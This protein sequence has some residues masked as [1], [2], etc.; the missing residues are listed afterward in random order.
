MDH[1]LKFCGEDARRLRRANQPA[2]LLASVKKRLPRPDPEVQLGWKV[3]LGLAEPKLP[4]WNQ[5]RK[6]QI[7]ELVGLLPVICLTHVF[8]GLALVSILWG[9]APDWQ[10]LIWFGATLALMMSAMRLGRRSRKE[11]PGVAPGAVRR[12]VLHAI[13]SGILWTIPPA[14]FSGTGTIEQQLAICLVSAGVIASAVLTIS[15][16]PAA[17]LAF[18]AIASAGLTAMM[19]KAGSPLMTML[20]LVYAFCLALGGAAQGRAFIGRRWAEIAL[21]EKSEVV[22][23]LLREFEE[24][25]A[26][27]L[28]QVDGAKRLHHVG[29]HLARATGQEPAALEG[30]P[31]LRILAG[32]A[33]ESGR[34]SP[35]LKDL[36][37]RMNARESFSGIE[38]PVTVNGEARWWCLSAAPRYDEQGNFTGFRGVGSDV[39]EQRRSAEKIDRMARFDSLTGLANRVHFIDV[40]RKALARAFRDGGRCAL[41]LIDLDK[42]K[43]VN[44]TLGHPVGDK[45]LKLVAQRLGNLVAGDDLCGRLGGDEFAM[46]IAEAGDWSRIEK[47]GDAVIS[48]MTAPFEIDGD[49]VRIG[50]SVGTAVGPRDGRSVE[51]LLR[52]A[53]LALYRAKDDGRGVHRRFEPSLLIRAEKRRAI[54]SALRE[55]LDNDQLR[56]VYQPVVDAKDERI[57]GFEALL[58][59]THPELGEVAPNEFL[60]IAEEA[61]LLGR[62][63]DWVL[64][65]AC[66]EATRW[67]A[68]TRLYV[69]L[70]MEQ[71]HDPQLPATILS[72]LS[73]AGLAPSRLELEISEAIFLRD[74]AAATAALDRVQGIGVRAALDDFG[75]GYSALGYVRQGRFSTIKIDRAFVGTAAANNVESLAIIRAVVAMADTLGVATTAEGAETPAEYRLA[76][77]LGCRQIQGYISGAPMTPEEARALAGRNARRVA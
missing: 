22:S 69:N 53:D 7:A 33:W 24:H 63:G 20:P 14:F 71:L 40:A 44:D 10:L 73:Y 4:G 39:T 43:A 70:S 30:V 75:T 13:V 12:A 37:E 41:M 60:P 1:T 3:V 36:L 29:A 47:L 62:I 48:A 21:A 57:A 35:E 28:W 64:R 27:W 76:R 11:G 8:N 18:I 45:L 49:M 26:D 65:T 50:A 54:E 17:M 61:R 52:N 68:S 6:A 42:F 16:V 38:L 9:S 74:N 31:F 51:M 19:T 66:T 5:L 67:P 55:A 59:W 77:D 58:R 25:D 15:V 32:D 46:M 2:L 23:L 72:A 34:L 56:L